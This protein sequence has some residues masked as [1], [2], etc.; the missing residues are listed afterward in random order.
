MTEEE[1]L[2]AYFEICRRT[3]EQMERDG[4][5]PWLS[6]STNPEDAVESDSNSKIP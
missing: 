3:Y 2:Q 4:T 6:D 5:W 1:T